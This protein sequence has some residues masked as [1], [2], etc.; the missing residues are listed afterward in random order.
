MKFRH[1]VT[2]CLSGLCILGR[3]AFCIPT[4]ASFP[5]LRNTGNGLSIICPKLLNDSACDEPGF[6]ADVV[7]ERRKWQI[8]DTLSLALNIC[9]W[10]LDAELV[11]AVLAAAAVTVGKRSAVGI[12]EKTFIQKSKNKYNTLNFEI[13]PD[14]FNPG[15]TW[16]D[17][18]EI[19]GDNGLPKFYDETRWWR[20][21]H[22]E[23]IHTTKGELG[24]GAVRRWWQ[25]ERSKGN[26]STA[27]G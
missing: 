9:S 2:V 20:M 7:W 24:H 1:S 4:E 27:E 14:H 26:S 18:A 10:K 12:L 19:L 16:A 15:L 21:L 8:S 23:V 17:I 3:T 11:Q 13:S 5:N 6:S 22:F 25:L